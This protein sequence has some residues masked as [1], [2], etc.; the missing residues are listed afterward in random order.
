MIRINEGLSK[1]TYRGQTYYEANVKTKDDLIREIDRVKN[2]LKSYQGDDITVTSDDGIDFDIFWHE[3]SLNVNW[4]PIVQ[5]TS[6]HK[7]V[8]HNEGTENPD[9]WYKVVSDG[10]NKVRSL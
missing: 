5:I 4:Y 10:L 7:T 8:F 1:Q 3:P 9:Y 2:D 6:N